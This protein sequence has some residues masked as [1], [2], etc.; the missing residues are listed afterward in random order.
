MS[1]EVMEEMEACINKRCG[2]YS[3]GMVIYELFEHR[4]PLSP[5]SKLEMQSWQVNVPQ[6]LVVFLHTSCKS[7]II[8]YWKVDPQER[9][10]FAA[11]VI[12][13]ENE[14]IITP[15]MRYFMYIAML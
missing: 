13:F 4:V 8:A 6:S 1:P 10:T 14:T 9:P 12:A 15:L 2:A 5:S 11:I 3:Y 7:L